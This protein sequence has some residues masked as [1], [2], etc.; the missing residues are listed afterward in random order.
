MDEHTAT[1][2]RQMCGGQLTNEMQQVYAR[3]K[4][5]LDRGSAGGK[6]RPSEIAILVGLA[7]HFG[8]SNGQGRIEIATE[9]D[10][11]EDT[12]SPETSNPAEDFEREKDRPPVTSDYDFGPKDDSV[13]QPEMNWKVVPRLTPVVIRTKTGDVNGKF[14]QPGRNGKVRVQVDGDEKLYR[15]VDPDDVTIIGYQT[16]PVLGEV[17]N[18]DEE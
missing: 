17:P 3:A 14:H 5:A 13:I 1:I 12:S 6:F 18:L 4:M 7:K 11:G 8:N 15:E 9:P 2:I 16:G 10:E